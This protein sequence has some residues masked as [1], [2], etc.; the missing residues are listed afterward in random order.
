MHIHVYMRIWHKQVY[1][2]EVTHV[3]RCGGQRNISCIFP[4]PLSPYLFIFFNT[5]SH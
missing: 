4:N 3:C 5:T 2:G 1:A